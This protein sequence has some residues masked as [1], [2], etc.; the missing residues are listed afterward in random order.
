MPS[1][2]TVG[3]TDATIAFFELDSQVLVTVLAAARPPVLFLP[4]KAR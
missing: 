4:P 2:E 1:L 3:A